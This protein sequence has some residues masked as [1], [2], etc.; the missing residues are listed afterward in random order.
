MT[1]QLSFF[2]TNCHNKRFDKMSKE[3]LS[4]ELYDWALFTKNSIFYNNTYTYMNKHKRT[5]QY[6]F[7]LIKNK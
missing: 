6:I 7:Q 1:T 2:K 5:I 3:E 4:K